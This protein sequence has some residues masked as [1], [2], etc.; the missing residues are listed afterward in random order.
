M[1]LGSPEIRENVARV[2]EAIAASAEK[3][4]RDPAEVHLIAVSKGFPVEAVINACESGL[5][6]FGENYAQ[7]FWDKHKS[8][9]ERFG[10]VVN[11]HFIG[12]LQKNKVKYVVGMVDLIHSLDS[13]KVALEI[14]KRSAKAG[15]ITTSV[16]LEVNTASIPDRGGIMKE[17]L[18][19]FLAQIS[20][21]EH[22]EVV[23]L[24]TMAP[25]CEHAEDARPYF[26]ALRELRDSLRGR[27]PRLRELSMGMTDD[28]TVAIEE[29]ATYVRIGRAVFGP[30]DRAKGQS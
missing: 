17:D 16:L 30:R 1:V 20:A 11:W 5:R 19:D 28:Y 9:A 29:G 2:R 8:V 27:Y 21:L 23:G 7:E 3:A 24:M 25:L 26:R 4:G 13:I 18:G 6:E 22:V 14:E 15:V 10:D 12:K